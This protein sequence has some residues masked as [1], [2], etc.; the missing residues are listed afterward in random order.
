[1]ISTLVFP[2]SMSKSLDNFRKQ[3]HVN[4]SLCVRWIFYLKINGLIAARI[5]IMS[6][7]EFNL[8]EN[9]VLSLFSI[10]S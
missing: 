8:S 1:M 10:R 9:K 5:V 6:S 7:F 4:A 3:Y 2:F